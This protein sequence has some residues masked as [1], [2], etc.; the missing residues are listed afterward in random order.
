MKKLIASFFLIFNFHAHAQS[1]NPSLLLEGQ[2]DDGMADK[3]VEFLS[4]NSGP[5]TLILNGPGG[6]VFSAQRIENAIRSA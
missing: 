4:N 3:T 6:D 2:V 5:V 1:P